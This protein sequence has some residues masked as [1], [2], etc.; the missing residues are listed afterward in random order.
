MVPGDATFQFHHENEFG[1][2]LEMENL[3]HEGV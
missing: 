2:V 1:G 3:F